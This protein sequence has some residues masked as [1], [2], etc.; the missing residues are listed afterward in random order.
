MEGVFAVTS[1]ARSILSTCLSRSFVLDEGLLV[2]LL[3]R[4]EEL[5]GGLGRSRP[6]NESDSMW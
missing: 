4:E 6:C 3:G 5:L 1:I 2:L